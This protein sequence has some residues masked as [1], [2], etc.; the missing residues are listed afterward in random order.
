MKPLMLTMTDDS[1]GVAERFLP[2][3]TLI[4]VLQSVSE[5]DSEGDT[6]EFYKP[7]WG[8]PLLSHRALKHS[9]IRKKMYAEGIL[10]TRMVKKGG[11][12]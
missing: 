4:G 1:L 12:V 8:A 2:T 10:Y 9:P 7:V 3:Q 5:A 6:I 11:A